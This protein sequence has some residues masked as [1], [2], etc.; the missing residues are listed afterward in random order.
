MGGQVVIGWVHPAEV[1]AHFANALLATVVADLTGPQI[2]AG[3]I[4]EFS[5][6]NVAGPRNKIVRRFLDEHDADWLLFVDADM[7]WRPDAIRR[8]LSVADL[9]TPIVGGLCHGIAADELFST[10]FIFRDGSDGQ[11]QMTRLL[12][13]PDDRLVQCH[14]TGAAF[15]LIHR[16]VLEAVGAKGFDQAFPWF[17]ETSI[18]SEP[19]SEDLTFC[20]RAG[21]LGFPIFVHTGVEILHHKSTLL[22][23]QKLRDQ[24][25]LAALK[26]PS[27]EPATGSTLTEE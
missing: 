7:A 5:G 1:S 23:R 24:R 22:S 12:D 21:E 6:A 14:A 2:I 4:D 8:L 25:A 9:E 16:Q 18:G 27:V 11:R 19:V 3:T 26:T 20:L 10:I 17:Q 15:L 13:Y